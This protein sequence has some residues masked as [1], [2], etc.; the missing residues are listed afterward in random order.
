MGAAR[1]DEAPARE[2]NSFTIADSRLTASL[3]TKDG[4]GMKLIRMLLVMMF[5]GAL[6]LAAFGGDYG[7][8]TSA[9]LKAMIDRNEPGLVIIDSRS[10]SQFEESHIKGAISIPL[11][12]MEQDPALPKAPKDARLVFYCSG[13]T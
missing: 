9:E 5:V 12:D 2:I 1:G 10:Q 3:H 6:A 8:V 7:T 13:N 4:T 11:T